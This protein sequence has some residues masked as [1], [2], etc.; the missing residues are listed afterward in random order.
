MT[1]FKDISR[2]PKQLASEMLE[3]TEVEIGAEVGYPPVKGYAKMK[4]KF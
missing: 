3:G 2:K 1:K 4:K